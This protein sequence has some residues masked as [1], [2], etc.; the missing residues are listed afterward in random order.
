MVHY[1]QSSLLKS[2]SADEKD[3]IAVP[4]G[5]GATGAMRHTIQLLRNT[6]YFGSNV[7]TIFISPY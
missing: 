1:A 6:H 4:A 7:P 2:F 3:Y 5:S